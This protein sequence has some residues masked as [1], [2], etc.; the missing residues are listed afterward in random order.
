MTFAN[1]NNHFLDNYSFFENGRG[2][3]YWLTLDA[4]EVVIWITEE[5]WV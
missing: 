3:A 4:L 2:D 5:V 1:I